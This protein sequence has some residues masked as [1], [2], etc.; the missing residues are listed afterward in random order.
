M[1]N[2]YQN[3]SQK[4]DLNGKFTAGSGGLKSLKNFNWGRALPII[5]IVGLVGGFLVWQSFAATSPTPG[6]YK[7]YWSDEFSTNSLDTSRWGA[8]NNTYGD[9]NQE[10]ACLTPANVTSSGGSLKITAKKEAI[11]CPGSKQ[12]QFSSGFIGSRDSPNK[13]YYP[14]FAKYEIRAKVPHGQ[15][16]WPAFWLRHVDGS[17]VAE[18]DVMEYFHA[19]AP[20]KI[21]Q[22]L[23]LP[24]EVGRNVAKKSTNF[25]VARAGVGDWHTYAV[26]IAPLD[27]GKKA[28]FIYFIDGTE[29]LRYTPSSFNWLNNYDK[30]HMF[31]IALNMAVGGTWN[32]HPDDEL[33]WSRYLKYC[34]NPGSYGK[35]QPCGGEKSGLFKAQFPSSYEIDYVRVYTPETSPVQPSPAPDSVKL[36]TPSNLKVEATPG[37]AKLSWD[38]SKDSRVSS[39]SV[40]YIDSSS[41]TKSNGSTWIYPGRVKSTSQTITGL[42]PGVSYDFQIRSNDDNGNTPSSAYSSTILS[43]ALAPT[44]IG[45]SASYY[46]SNNFTGS[47]SSRIDKT[48]DFNWGEST[49]TPSTSKDF[50]A[51]WVGQ[52]IAPTSED[53]TISLSGDDGTALWL[54]GKQV[55]NNWSWG[56]QPVRE[57]SAT[58]KLEAGKVNS[59]E[60]DYVDYKSDAQ[61]KLSWQTSSISKR[62]IPASAFVP[63][64]NSGLS[65]RYYGN[66]LQQLVNDKTVNFDW[67]TSSP[68]EPIPSDGFFV[69]WVGKIAVPSSGTY[70][71]S[72]IADDGITLFVDGKTI[73]NDWGN[74]S[75]RKRSGSI[76]LEA[77]KRYSINIYYYE[78][79]G[80]AVAKLLWKSTSLPEEV[81]PASALFTN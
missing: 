60:V 59:I 9:G 43:T 14:A 75:A 16:L 35:Q 19:Q 1:L 40:R 57:K 32:G 54:N 42:S 70:T 71:L 74:H 22:T 34:L 23:H 33:G 69:N 52:L 41:T 4:R 18:V 44:P 77:G 80:N 66:S 8:Y 62:V 51:R 29:T 47:T 11:T 53:Y 61:I 26:E 30:N 64:V 58:V 24:K 12:D 76:Y 6:N 7:L 67:T 13:T 3:R 45:L 27:G 68:F 56:S 5:A 39:Y 31:D 65:S 81:V 78:N 36:P 28:E 25:E 63:A 38:T 72:T 49:P 21:T 79:T 2:K 48:I 46:S 10:E 37:G 55:I 20:G 15:G 73:V 17:G 50:A